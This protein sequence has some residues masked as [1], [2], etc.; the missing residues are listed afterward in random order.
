[1]DSTD[2]VKAKPKIEYDGYYRVDSTSR[3][4]RTSHIYC[5]G[6]KLKSWIEFEKS[7]QSNMSVEYQLVTESEYMEH[8]WTAYPL[9]DD[10]SVSVLILSS[11]PE[12]IP[13]TVKVAKVKKTTKLATTD[14]DIGKV[15]E[16]VEKPAPKKRGRKSQVSLEDFI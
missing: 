6:N 15:K 16:F 9:D 1:M 7:L 12:K 3:N 5:R 8:H 2:K 4:G 13:E 10:E 14:R 11:Q